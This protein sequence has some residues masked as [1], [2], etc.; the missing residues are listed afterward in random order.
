MRVLSQAA[1]FISPSCALRAGQGGELAQREE[2][3]HYEHCVLS[4]WQRLLSPLKYQA[5]SLSKPAED[6]VPY[7]L[8]GDADTQGS[9]DARS[10]RIARCRPAVTFGIRPD[11]SRTWSLPSVNRTP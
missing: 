10:P 2:R 3:R 11:A 8:H 4:S 9:A 6:Q 7:L 1:A 5:D